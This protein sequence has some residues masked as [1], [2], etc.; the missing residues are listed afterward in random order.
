MTAPDNGSSRNRPF[1]EQ[2]PGFVRRGRRRR[3]IIA[4]GA[5][6]G[7]AVVAGI[8]AWYGLTRPGPP[9]LRPPQPPC[10]SC[11]SDGSNH[12]GSSDAGM[13]AVMN[14]IATENHKVTAGGHYD[15]IAL[16][17]PLTYVQ[18]GVAS[19]ERLTDSL[20][21]A[22]LAQLEA[23]RNDV[24]PVQLLL[25]NEGTTVEGASEEKAIP[26][27]R[28][29]LAMEQSEHVVAVAG[30]GISIPQTAQAAQLLSKARM[31]MFGSVTSADGFESDSI[32]GIDR[33]IPDVSQQVDQLSKLIPMPSNAV[34]VAD[35]GDSSF[36]SAAPAGSAG[37]DASF[38]LAANLASRFREVFHVVY[39][40][41]YVPGTPETQGEFARIA[42]AVCA[43]SPTATVFFAGRGSTLDSL[44]GQF[45]Q[46]TACAG[47]EITIVSGSDADALDRGETAITPDSRIKRITVTYAAIVDPN[48]LQ[49]A[50][51]NDYPRD[52]ASI[53]PHGTGL[54]D[55]WTTDTYDAVAA[56]YAAIKTAEEDIAAGNPRSAQLP[57]RAG[58]WDS[59]NWTISG[60]LSFEGSTGPLA[61][62]QDGRLSAP[63]VPV[64]QDSDGG[65]SVLSP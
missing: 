32:L 35:M 10:S 24:V 57:D 13:I 42:D 44:I 7:I 56:A 38:D 23:N 5:A 46:S 2:V 36:G 37:P 16:L 18:A 15:S 65:Q 58:V 19:Q 43:K 50:F 30:L 25:V 4:G 62:G 51:K 45:Q 33:A 17:L 20:R 39:E 40:R 52:L 53:D 64:F 1:T 28:Q 59:A 49:G 26:A 47:Q 55:G 48:K 12:F 14:A 41:G 21:G 31:P 6:L 9:V 8:G 27:A 61:I 34:L 54:D 22:Y 63:Q 60:D 11:V 29:I 3:R